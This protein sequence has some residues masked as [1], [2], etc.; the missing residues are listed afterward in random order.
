MGAVFLARQKKLRRF[1]AIKVINASI[2]QDPDS[3]E[4]FLRE[5]RATASFSHPNL[6]SVFDC[7]QF[8]GQSF[9]AMEYMEGM[10]LA[11]IIRTHGALPLPLAF[12]WLV[13]AATALE[14]IHNKH[15][16]HRDIK[17]DNMMIDA[18]TNLKIMDLGLAKDHL[19]TDQSMT[20]TGMIMGSPHYMSPEQINDSKTAD[21]RSDLYSLG[22]SFFQ[23]LIGHVP[24]RYSSSSLVCIAH[25]Q[26]P[27]PSLSLPD[28]ELTQA[29]D[30][31]IGKMAAKNKEERFQSATEI[32]AAVQPWTASN[33]IDAASQQ[34]LSNLG[35][36]E[37]SVS[38]ILEKKGVP[39]NEVDAD[40]TETPSAKEAGAQIPPLQQVPPTIEF[41][42]PATPRKSIVKW[43]VVGFA[44]CI[45]VL[46]GLNLIPH[47]KDQAQKTENSVDSVPTNAPVDSGTSNP[48]AVTSDSPSEPSPPAETVANQ[49]PAQP[50]PPPSSTKVSNENLFSAAEKGNTAAL[51]DLLDKGADVNKKDPNG[52][53]ALIIATKKGQLGAVNLLLEKGANMDEKGEEEATAL[54]FAIAGGH[55]AVAKALIAKGANVNEKNKDG[56]TALMCSVALNNPVVTQ[57]MLGKEETDINAKGQDGN[58]PLI[59]ASVLGHTDIVKMLLE[60]NAAIDEKNQIGDTALFS[61]ANPEIIEALLEKGADINEKNQGGLNAFFC[62]LGMNQPENVKVFLKHGSKINGKNQ[63]NQTPLMFAAQAGQGKNSAVIRL[64]LENRADVNATDGGSATA[65]MYAA[66]NG[67]RD[68]VQLLRNAGAVGD[69]YSSAALGETDAVARF[70]TKHDVNEKFFYNG[71]TALWIAARNGHLETVQYLIQHKAN[72]NVKTEGEKPE[73]CVSV[74]K[75]AKEQGHD[76]IVEVLTK[77]SAK[78]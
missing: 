24:F 63:Y 46:I 35:F 74:L 1:C 40:F 34:F 75:A 33:P 27:I 60:K 42:A 49:P 22:I 36:E 56:N 16:I 51:K 44:S 23:M 30:V 9:I 58:T 64:L 57:A 71:Q 25:L 10:S 8:E 61:A 77:A 48:I 29:L 78:E 19:D 39:E 73:E 69:L 45:L 72:V 21:H 7:D 32:L 26:E 67:C 11:E 14:Y 59:A 55:N 52:N 70:L 37:R 50:V 12:H 47:S 17:P 4:R 5:A 38:Y 6:I 62:S 20:V 15:V 53:T 68:I 31:L 43:I 76:N 2:S 3:T 54:M 18:K 65:L 13:Q 41:K 66:E 28:S